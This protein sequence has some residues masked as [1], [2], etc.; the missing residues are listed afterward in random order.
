MFLLQPIAE[1]Y[2][3]EAQAFYCTLRNCVLSLSRR[4]KISL[5]WN[6]GSSRALARVV[7]CPHHPLV[8]WV[9][10]VAHRSA[11]C[12]QVPQMTQECNKEEFH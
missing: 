6:L 3:Q 1:F 12:H 5:Q 11:Q 10:P 2:G 4:E 9:A 7:V 8:V